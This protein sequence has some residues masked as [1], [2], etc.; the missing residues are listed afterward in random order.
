MTYHMVEDTETSFC[1]RSTMWTT[2]TVLSW[3][4][5]RGWAEAAG[6]K[7]SPVPVCERVKLNV[8][9]PT[10]FESKGFCMYVCVVAGVHQS[11]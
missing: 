7:L 2:L 8:D 1:L 10:T 5:L 6:L 9:I 11:P 3:V 4:V